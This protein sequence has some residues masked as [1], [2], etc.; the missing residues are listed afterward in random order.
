MR[1]ERFEELPVWHR[2][3]SFRCP[4]AIRFKRLYLVLDNSPA[5]LYASRKR[6]ED[7][8]CAS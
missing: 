3:N 2:V 7:Y 5:A 4:R 8:R 1:Y 6:V